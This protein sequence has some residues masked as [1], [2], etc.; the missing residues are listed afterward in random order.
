MSLTLVLLLFSDDPSNNLLFFGRFH[1]LVVHLP[2]GFLLLAGLAEFSTKWKKFEPVQ[3]F[4]HYIWLLGV[5][6]AFFAVLF[7]YFLSLSGDYSEDIIFWHKWGGI[8]ILI[9]SSVYYFISKR[10][11]SIPF[12]GN[13]ILLT[14][15]ILMIFYTGHL[16]GNLTHGSTYLFEYAPNPIRQLAGLP[17]KSMPRKNFTK[18]DSVDIYSDL[19]SPIID[20]RCVSCHNSEK[21]KGDLNLTSFSSLMKGG[22]SGQIIIPGD[23]NTSDLFRRITLPM[24]HK[25]FM[26]TEGKQPLTADQVQLIGWWIKENAPS[27]AYLKELDPDKEITDI[28]NRQLGLDD[29]NFL[30]QKV[31]PPKKETIASLSKSGFILNALMKENYFLEANYS[32]SE[33][34]LTIQS[35]ETLLKLKKQLIWLNLT[36]SNLSDDKLKKI[37]ELERLMKLNLS[38]T[39]ISDKGLAHLGNLKKLK[40]LNLYKTKVSEE[41]L[42]VI[43]KLPNLKRLYLSET[44]ATEDIVSQLNKKKQNLEIIFNSN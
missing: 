3:A 13:S 6:S 24:D 22:E 11:I 43:P 10:Q 31:Q 29:Y 38:K 35:V 27:S 30:R 44:N 7:G 8:G 19:I 16:G 37:G 9:L 15:I 28:V 26:P 34:E 23:I 39:N 4:V 17:N 18:I 36:D 40:S 33:K 42:N 32:L 21:K 1:S 25:D 20:R 2:I 41:L 12:K 5:I 14:A